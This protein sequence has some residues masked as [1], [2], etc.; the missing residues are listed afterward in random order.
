MIKYHIYPSSM[1]CAPDVNEKAYMRFYRKM[2]GCV[3]DVIFLAKADRLS[4]QGIQVTKEMT[5]NNINAL[6]NLLNNY[7]KIKKEIKPL[8]KLLDGKE[9]MD[10]LK[11]EQGPKL[12]KIIKILKEEQLSGNITTKEDAISYIIRTKFHD[13]TICRE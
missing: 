6:N 13:E 8:P 2:D 12:G 7:L 4:A 1:V 10:I 5:E 11:I 9:I 3:I